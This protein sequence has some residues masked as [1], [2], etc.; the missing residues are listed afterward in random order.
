MAGRALHRVPFEGRLLRIGCRPPVELLTT[1]RTLEQRQRQKTQAEFA[2]LMNQKRR[3][4]AG[5]DGQDL[6]R[7][8][9][10]GYG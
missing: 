9:F 6:S 4:L 5:Y 1:L 7:V 3:I 8:D 2:A 10:T